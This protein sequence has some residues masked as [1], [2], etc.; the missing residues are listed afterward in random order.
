MSLR[1]IAATAQCTPSYVT[2]VCQGKRRSR[3]VA[4]LLAAPL[5]ETPERL[6]PELY[7]TSNANIMEHDPMK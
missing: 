1:S 3:E 4:E 5:G 6:W 2:M 7:R